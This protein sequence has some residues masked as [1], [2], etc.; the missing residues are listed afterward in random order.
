M[1]TRSNIITSIS[2]DNDLK[3]RIKREIKQ[4]G[5]MSFSHFVSICGRLLL[6]SDY[7]PQTYNEIEMIRILL[8]R[9]IGILDLHEELQL[10]KLL[11]VANEKGEGLDV[12]NSPES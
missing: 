1:K 4:L 2:I 12:G 10:Q 11:E 9:A 7:I 5:G 3:Q 6:D 8:V